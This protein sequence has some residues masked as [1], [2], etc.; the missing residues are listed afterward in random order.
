DLGIEAAGEGGYARELSDEEKAAQ[1][2]SLTD[3]IKGFDVV[4][5]TALGPGRPAPKLVTAE[6]VEGMRPGSVIIDLAGETGG[7]CELTAPGEVV[8]VHDGT[9]AS[10]RT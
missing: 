1:Q 3:A 4:I 6:A 9:I 10:P 2:Q 7:N 8:V 5:T